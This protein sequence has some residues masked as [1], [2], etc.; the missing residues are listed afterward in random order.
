[1][2]TFG[3]CQSSTAESSVPASSVDSGAHMSGG[4]WPKV[5]NA[6]TVA[7]NTTQ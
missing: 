5:Q 7:A 1:M 4:V 3:V 2:T 6:A